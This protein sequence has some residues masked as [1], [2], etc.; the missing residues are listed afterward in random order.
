VISVDPLSL[1]N[2]TPSGVARQLVTFFCFAKKKVTKEKATPVRRCFAVPSVT[3]PDRPPHKLARSAARPRAQT[4][5]SDYPCLACATRRRTG[6]G[7][8]KNQNQ[9]QNQTR[10]WAR[11]A[12]L[13]K[14][15]SV[16]TCAHPTTSSPPPCRGRVREGVEFPL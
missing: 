12:H 5:S 7:K 6:E 3:Q 15:D 4:Y 11:S 14:E 16:G 2:P 9:D 8:A 13:P 1:S 10:S